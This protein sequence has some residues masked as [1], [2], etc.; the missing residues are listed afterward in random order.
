MNSGVKVYPP[1]LCAV[2]GVEFRP[3]S[4]RTMYCDECREIVDKKWRKE[5]REIRNARARENYKRKKGR[6]IE[7]PLTWAEIAR[8]CE[9]HNLS[10]GQAKARGLI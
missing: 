9:E 1:I 2:C 6:P 8:I 10:Y 7:K 4:G 3:R 5:Y